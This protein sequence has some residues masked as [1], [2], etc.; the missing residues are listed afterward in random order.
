[1]WLR[2][3]GSCTNVTGCHEIRGQSVYHTR[4]C[5]TQEFLRTRPLRAYDYVTNK[6]YLVWVEQPPNDV[7]QARSCLESLILLFFDHHVS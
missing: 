4:L 6:R 5:F 2:Y 7:E 1:M 3:L